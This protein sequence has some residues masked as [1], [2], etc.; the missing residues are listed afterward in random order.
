MMEYTIEDTTTTQNKKTYA[1]ILGTM[2]MLY[3]AILAGRKSLPSNA[4][5]SIIGVAMMMMNAAAGMVNNNVLCR[6]VLDV[7]ETSLQRKAR[8]LVLQLMPGLDRFWILIMMTQH[9]ILRSIFIDI[10][11][12]LENVTVSHGMFV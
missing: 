7:G 10:D 2:A 5:K 3:A 8:L 1:R 12:H 4:N 9:V 6:S 11:M